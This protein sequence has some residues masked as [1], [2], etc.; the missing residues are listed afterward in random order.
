V[1]IA[2]ADYCGGCCRIAPAQKVAAT[3]A[4][5]W[6]RAGQQAYGAYGAELYA[7]ESDADGGGPWAL[8]AIAPDRTDGAVVSA[9]GQAPAIRQ[10][11]GMEGFSWA[12]SVPG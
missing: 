6:I 5:S 4:P 7:D 9:A 12:S 1:E 11:P 8:V 2:E 3:R 10:C